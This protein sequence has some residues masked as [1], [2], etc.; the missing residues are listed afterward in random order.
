MIGSW[1]MSLPKI[2]PRIT[3]NDTKEISLET[4]CHSFKVWEL[5]FPFSQK[6]DSKTSFVDYLKIKL[7]GL[8]IDLPH[9]CSVTLIWVIVSFIFKIFFG[10][11]YPQKKL[12][13]LIIYSA[14]TGHVSKI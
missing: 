1:N 13:M 11:F 5:P 10:E 14:N 4:F 3:A 8:Y 7:S 6:V 2:L 12:P 9:I